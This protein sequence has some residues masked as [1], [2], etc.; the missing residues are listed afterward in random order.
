MPQRSRHFL[1]G[2]VFLGPSARADLMYQPA[3]GLPEWKRSA[4]I[5]LKAAGEMWMGLAEFESDN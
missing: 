3:E 1:D 4:G 5:F 2:N